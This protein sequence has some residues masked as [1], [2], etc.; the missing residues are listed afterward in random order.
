MQLYI[1]H[2]RPLINSDEKLAN[3]R[4]YLFTSSQILPEKPLGSQVDHSAIAN[5]MAASFQKAEVLLDH[6]PT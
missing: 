6:F 5:A 1:E 4:P 3:K 2:Y